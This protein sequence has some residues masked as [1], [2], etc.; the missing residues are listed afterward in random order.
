[1]KHTRNHMEDILSRG[2]SGFHQYV[3]EDPVHISYVSENLCAMAGVTE[4]ELLSESED[5]Y[6]TLVHPADQD[7]YLQFIQELKAG[8]GTLSL[9]YRLVKKDGTLLYVKDT[10]VSRRR[11]DGA[12]VGDSVLADVTE[13]KNENDNL[14][15]LSETVPCGF[16]RYT[17]EK[18]PKVT[19]IN[20][21][22]KKILRIP[23]AKEGELDYLELY[24]D[25]I[26]LMVP[27][28][29]RSRLA[30]YLDRV[31]K[32]GAPLAGEVTLLRCDGTR[33]YIFG[34]VTRCVNEQGVEEFQTACMDVTERH[35]ARKAHEAKR[36]LKA[37]TEVYDKVFAYNL[38]DSTVTCLY[39]NNSPMFRWMENIPMQMEEATEKWITGT[40]VEEERE[41]VRAYFRAF[42]QRKL[43]Q[44]DQKPTQITYRA[45]S[46]SGQ[47]K[48]YRG[49][50]LK[51]DEAM[52]FY[53][54]RCVS[55]SEEADAL[56]SEN[57]SLRE[58]IQELMTRFSEGVAA[59][60]VADQ[61]V[62]PLYASDNVCEFFGFTREEWVSLM[63]RRTPLREFVARG[64]ASYEKVEELLQNGE[65]EFTYY[66]LDR[67]MERRV[68]AI[69]SPKNPEASPRY[70][71]LYNIEATEAG[72]G[73]KTPAAP[74]VSIR[75]FG[76]FDVFVGEKPIAFRNKKSKELFALLVDRRGG[77]VTSEEA[78]SFLWEEEPVNSV[79]LARY[80]KVALRLKNIL[81]EYGI[82]EVVEAV[83]G[84][85][86]IVPEKVKCDLYDY[87]SGRE[88]YA[89]LFKGSYLANYS[90]GENT[91][92][93][94][95][96]TM[97][98]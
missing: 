58:N 30:R 87:L 24:R 57:L 27:M 5:L 64:T 10:A 40:V 43:Y 95:T 20:E 91:L 62:T 85:R 78:I 72:G 88:E 93:Q 36:Y 48:T 81:E 6:L 90:W 77:Y 23:E 56:R 44:A 97:L 94:L 9:E 50:F 11:E 51:T 12:L 37:L 76:Y 82:S 75:T 42:Q 18:Q 32:A 89:Q 45:K 28:E 17:C 38:S 31:Y 26:F 60:E 1:M 22:M 19:Y 54:C 39:S 63:N 55:D 8:E 4:A 71:M 61:C 7:R 15:F 68:R 98:Y 16:L 52:S 74:T 84:K 21:Q 29:E 92:A 47:V 70:V 67:E 34:W 73:A 41:A 69:C 66:D 49:I 59:F 2:I 79:T 96:G 46:S 3:L 80:R 83:D 86:R 13:M 33:A 65:A 25:N 35:Q 53:C 14:R